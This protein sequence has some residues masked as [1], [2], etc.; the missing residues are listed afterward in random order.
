MTRLTDA[1]VIGVP[2]CTV[3]YSTKSPFNADNS[4]ILVLEV[5]NF[6]LYD[7]AT[8]KRLGPIEWLGDSNSPLWSTSDPYIFYYLYA[9]AICKCDTRLL[10]NGRSVVRVFD[11]YS[12]I[13]DKGESDLGDGG[14]LALLG[15][16]ADG[17]GMND[18]FIYTI[19]SDHKGSA[20]LA[21][22]D[23]D[24]IYITPNGNLIASYPVEGCLLFDSGMAYI[25]QLTTLSGHKDVMRDTD[26]SEVMAI[27]DNR[28][29]SVKKIRLSDDRV[30]AI[31]PSLPWDRAVHI[32]CPDAAGFC[33]VSTYGPGVAGDLLQVPLTPGEPAVNLG[34]HGSSASNYDSQPHASVSRDGK[35]LAF[36]S[37]RDGRVD[38]YLMELP[39]NPNDVEIVEGPAVTL[40]R[41][42]NQ[43]PL[44]PENFPAR[45]G[46]AGFIYD[47]GDSVKLIYNDGVH[48][49]Q[50]P[51]KMV[52]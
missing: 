43:A 5:A 36:N 19:N 27:A 38:V 41:F 37:D 39:P 11:E 42:D 23:L 28:D 20:G 45:P 24:A 44:T 10:P 29:N 49:W 21:G 31:V 47:G 9:N 50:W 51:G 14:R 12:S 34:K 25:R 2:A 1:A 32:S 40:W 26:G 22:A 13:T 35:W 17:S 33:I 30:T 46:E 8:S 6:A 3:Q 15:V 48:K 18:I 52:V 7:V 16:R 4:K